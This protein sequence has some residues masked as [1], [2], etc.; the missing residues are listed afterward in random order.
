[1][2]V[3]FIKMVGS[4]AFGKVYKAAWRG[5]IVAAKVMPTFGSANNNMKIIENEL[6]VYK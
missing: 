2:S 6:S 5:T 3:K 4:G 1:M